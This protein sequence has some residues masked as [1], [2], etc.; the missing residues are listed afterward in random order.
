MKIED[1]LI[2]LHKSGIGVWVQGDNL[3][4]KSIFGE[5]KKTDIEFLKN[6]KVAIINNLKKNNTLFNREIQNNEMPLTEIQSAYILGRDK[7]FKY[8]GVSSHVYIEIKL[9]LLDIN[10]AEEVWN[11]II[12]RHEALKTVFTPNHYQ[13]ILKEDTYYRIKYN[14]GENIAEKINNTRK[15]LES[16]VY[17]SNSWPL[18]DIIISQLDDYSIIHISFDFLVLDWTSIWIL[19]KEFEE[20]YFYES[21]VVYKKYSLKEIRLSQLALKESSKY[22]LDKEYWEHRIPKLP[23]GP[24]IPINDNFEGFSFERK[25]K[26]IDVNKWDK[27]KSIIQT[28]EVTQTSFLISILAIVLN[29]FSYNSHF[30]INLVTMNRPQEYYGAKVVNDFTA[31]NLLEFEINNQDR[32]IELLRKTQRQLIEDI[33]H[34]TFTGVEVIREIRKD[35]EKRDRIYPFVFTSAMGID[36]SNYKYIKVKKDGLSQTP[37]VFMDCQ[38][39]EVEGEL[40]INFDLRKGV[41]PSIII[42]TITDSYSKL[43]SYLCDISMWNCDISDIY[44]EVFNNNLNEIKK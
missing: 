5:P 41:I 6:N 36:S 1:K 14:N 21:E 11:N 9:P 13:K 25:Q 39:M 23:E 30:I 28:F 19:L 4:Y 26:K 3:R 29:R 20:L 16:K 35:P 10:K 15:K 22:L 38:V 8:G 17:N 31:T 34:D 12:N 24:M 2:E 27:L 44:G 32:F 40:I 42:E 37:Q 18:F 7:N 33:N 43:L